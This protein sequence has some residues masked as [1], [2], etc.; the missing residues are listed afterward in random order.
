MEKKRKLF[1]WEYIVRFGLICLIAISVIVLLWNYKFTSNEIIS[2]NESNEQ[3]FLESFEELKLESE[4]GTYKDIEDIGQKKASVIE[5]DREAYDISPRAFVKLPF[6]PYDWGKIKYAFDNGYY[7]ILSKATEDYYL[8]PEFYDNWETMGRSFYEN[9]NKVCNGGFFSLPSGQRLYTKAGSTVE[10]FMLV[11]SSFCVGNPQA[12]SFEAFYPTGGITDDGIEYE[13]D[14]DFIRRYISLDFD[15]NNVVLGKTY[16]GF[17]RDWAKKIKVLVSVSEMAPR[18]IYIV[19]VDTT[20]HD[21]FFEDR[22]NIN[23]EA[24]KSRGGS[25]LMTL[26]IAVD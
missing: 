1:E 20:S 11:H 2:L 9:L 14:P 24:Y 10:T 25:P 5:I 21:P 23:K 16:P 15:S 12:I 7:S 4:W 22:K 3:R 8:Q 17:E 13:Q 18:G 19:V 6:I 26:I